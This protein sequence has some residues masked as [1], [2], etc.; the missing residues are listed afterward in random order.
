MRE[1][2]V[3][4]AERVTR[5]LNDATER[6]KEVLRE[7]RGFVKDV[8]ALNQYSRNLIETE[9]DKEVAT[10]LTKW[11]RGIDDACNKLLHRKVEE[12]NA[13]FSQ[14]FSILN[15]EDK[16]SQKKGLK[17]ISELMDMAEEAQAEDE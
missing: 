8:I 6:A 16:K 5:E 17:P 4:R 1:T 3:Q 13:A 14:W 15:G 12:A 7:A 10:M 2:D 11:T 9:V